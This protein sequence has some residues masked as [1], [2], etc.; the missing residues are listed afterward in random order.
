ML[1]NYFKYNI[2][3]NIGPNGG[4]CGEIKNID[5]LKKLVKENTTECDYIIPCDADEFHEYEYKLDKCVKLMISNDDEYIQ[6]F[7]AERYCSS[8][9]IKSICN[10]IDIFAQ[11]DSCSDKLFNMPKISLIKSK[12]YEK[13][14][15]GHH[16]PNLTNSENQCDLKLSNIISKT[17]HFRWCTEGKIRMEKWIEFWIRYP[18][19]SGWK[20]IEKYTNQL[21]VFN[22]ILDY[23]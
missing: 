5:M 17:N 20:G 22:N 6:S 3:Y 14:G 1:A 21:K 2:V 12:H 16:Y 9:K 18:K 7:T 11:F 15:V 4:T 13:L 19:C 10:D 8:G 23:V